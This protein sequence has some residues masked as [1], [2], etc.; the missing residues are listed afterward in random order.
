MATVEERGML[1][2]ILSEVQTMAREFADL[3][4]STAAA[5]EELR[6]RGNQIQDHETRLRHLQES[7]FITR[8]EY[9]A[10]EAGKGAALR[11]AKAVADRNIQTRTAIIALCISGLA[12]LV[13]WFH[14]GPTL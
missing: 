3:R 5:V 8:K 9:E 10:I 6:H 11:I 13:A 2:Q 12:V 14:G 7:D 1:A 4:V